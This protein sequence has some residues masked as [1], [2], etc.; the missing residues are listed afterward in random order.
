MARTGR[1]CARLDADSDA[2]E[3]G[4]F[5]SARADR[6][7]TRESLLARPR[8]RGWVGRALL[9]PVVRASARAC[10]RIRQERRLPGCA[11]SA[12][13]QS[14][15]AR[16]R[17]AAAAT[18]QSEAAHVRLRGAHA[19]VNR[20]GFNNKGVDHLVAQL[21]P[22][23]LSG[24]FAASA[25]ARISIRRSRMPPK[26]TWPACARSTRT[27]ITSRST[28]PRRIPRGCVSCRR[29][30]GLERIVGALQD[31]REELSPRFGKRVPLLVKI[32]PDLDAEQISA[33][34]CIARA[35]GRRRDRHQYLDGSARALRRNCRRT[36]WAASAASRCTRVRSR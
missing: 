8:G 32:A 20:M 17:D 22:Q 16:N 10:G 27:P 1:A 34:A 9:R 19:I 13:F 26:I 14:H 6:I 21:G 11:G 33:L 23:P 12:R 35:A 2:P 18:R 36:N 31:A 29:E 7:E 28:S 4:A 24:A 3:S 15:R 5:A 30:T 25:S